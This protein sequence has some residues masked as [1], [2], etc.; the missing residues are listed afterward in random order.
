MHKILEKKNAFA[1]KLYCLLDYCCW[2]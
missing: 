2:W 1:C